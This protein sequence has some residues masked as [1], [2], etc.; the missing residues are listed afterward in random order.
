[1]GLIKV[2]EESKAAAAHVELLIDRAQWTGQWTLGQ[3]GRQAGAG[4]MHARL[5]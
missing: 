4:P 2:E 1:V 3:A 5:S